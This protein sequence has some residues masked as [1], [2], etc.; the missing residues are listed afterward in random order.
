MRPL[1]MAKTHQG[2]PQEWLGSP[3]RDKDNEQWA[4]KQLWLLHYSKY[5]QAKTLWGLHQFYSLCLVNE[6]LAWW[7]IP[8]KWKG[9]SLEFL[10]ANWPLGKLVSSVFFWITLLRKFL[11]PLGT[12]I[13]IFLNN[14]FIVFIK[15]VYIHS[16]L[17]FKW[18][19]QKVQRK[20]SNKLPNLT[21]QNQ[22]MLILMSIIADLTLHMRQIWKKRAIER[23]KLI[24]MACSVFSY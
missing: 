12:Y 1:G 23:K 22:L 7:Y 20:K 8:M 19:I 10:P 6:N 21:A 18:A 14:D 3:P 2:S 17:S 24:R 15:M 11:S 9:T 16:L 13:Y 5:L 4:D